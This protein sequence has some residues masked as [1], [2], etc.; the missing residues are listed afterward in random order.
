MGKELFAHKINILDG[1]KTSD[2]W[3]QSYDMVV[4]AEARLTPTVITPVNGVCTIDFSSSNNFS[5]SVSG[6]FSLS[7]SVSSGDVGQSGIITIQNT[8]TTVPANLPSTMLTSKG[9]NVAWHTTSGG[10]A[11]LSYYIMATD[12]IIVNYVGNFS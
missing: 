7:P 5:I 10:V 3:N 12:K 9:F 8:G 6:A 1:T 2:H 4:A 11:I